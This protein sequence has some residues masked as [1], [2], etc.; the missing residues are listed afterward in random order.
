[1]KAV[2]QRVTSASVA[3]ENQTIGA[4]GPGLLI[5]LGIHEEDTEAEVDYLVRKITKLRIFED[6]QGKMNLDLAAIAGEILSVSQF[7][8]YADTKKGNRPSYAKAARP[9]VATDLYALFNQKLREANITVAT[10]EFGAHM[11][12]ALVNDGPV[13][14]VI[15]TREK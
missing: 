11:Q 9:E 15:D 14:I 12:I 7:T 2:I 10:G 5:L 4:I 1:M 3:V 13:T 8:L 6:E